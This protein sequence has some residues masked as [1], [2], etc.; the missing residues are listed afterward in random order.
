MEQYK[1]RETTIA[2]NL[3]NKENDMLKESEGDRE[4]YHLEMSLF[5][6]S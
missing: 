5:S 4:N 3:C 1:T 2:N 6:T